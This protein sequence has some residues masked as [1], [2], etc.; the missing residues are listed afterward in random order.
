MS[1]DVCSVSL[2]ADID[3]VVVNVSVSSLVTAILTQ[4]MQSRFTGLSLTWIFRPN[5]NIRKLE[6]CHY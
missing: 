4:F 3:T 1:H 6:K 5:T 2:V